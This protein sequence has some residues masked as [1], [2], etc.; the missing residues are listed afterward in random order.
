MTL[1]GVMNRS[2]ELVRRGLDRDRDLPAT[3]R[4]RK[5]IRFVAARI[6]AKLLLRSCNAVG[7]RGR[8]IGV[9]RIVNQGSMK[10]GADMVLN[11]RFSPVELVTHPGGV[12]ELGDGV[13]INYGTSISARGLVRLGN[14]VSLGPYCIVADSDSADE[15]GEWAPSSAVELA[16]DVW[17]AGRVTILPG[18]HVGAGSVITAGSVVA[19]NIPAGVVAGGNPARVVRSISAEPLPAPEASAVRADEEAFEGGAPERQVGG[20]SD[21]A[22]PCEPPDHRGLILADFT[23]TDLA[24]AFGAL[25]GRPA[26][27]AELGPFGEVAQQ[28]LSPIQGSTNTTDFS[29]VW[30]RPETA[31]GGYARLQ[32]GQTVSPTDLLGEVDAFCD[33]L[34]VGAERF[35]FT[36]VPSWTRPA[37]QRGLGLGDARS[38]QGLARAIGSMN[39]RLMERLAESPTVFVLDAERWAARAGKG[40]YDE[41]LWYLGKVPFG[42]EMFAEAALDIQAALGS[43]TGGG[44]KLLIL[45]LDE[46]LWG[47]I[48]GEEGWEQLRLGGHDSVGEAFVAFQRSIKALTMRG[49]VLGIVSKNEEAVALEAIRKHPEMVLRPDDFVGWRINWND[50]AANIVELAA[51]LN[52]GLQ[53][54]V[55]IDDSPIERARV[56]EALPEVLVPEWPENK[57]HYPSAL[58][59]LR[60]FDI[61]ATTREDSERTQLYSAERE[62][63]DLRREVGSLDDWLK[64]LEIKVRAEPLAASNVTRCV[65]LLNKVNQMNLATRRLTE[66]ELLA[67]AKHSN[68]QLWLLGVTDRMGDSGLTGLLSLETEGSV[69]KVVDFVLSCR[70]MGRHIEETMT[71]LAVASARKQGLSR[72][73]ATLLPTPKNSPCLA[74]WM[75]SGFAPEGEQRFSWQTA[76]EYPLPEAVRLE[77]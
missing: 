22:V 20:T 19:G 63:R 74:Y 36:F 41:S 14:H 16:D 23:A 62:R 64:G 33:R 49:V 34:L 65:Q 1:Q 73:E 39:H 26:L 18:S 25:G 15:E 9:P 58:S 7:P 6:S 50:K 38:E 21:A 44:R 42:R 69:A 48:V 57:L 30:T 10:L 56:R 61:Q 60:C 24:A 12:L 66:T 76:R 40:A 5:G 59:Q 47:G 46:T 29:V 71:H 43:L 32:D 68:V 13:A 52:L 2:L 27:A 54:V 53:S 51:E 37:W 11:S 28:L 72:V 8:T 3:V 45:D 67:W 75:R 31:I 55:F 35:R 17:L 77:W 70:V 4:F